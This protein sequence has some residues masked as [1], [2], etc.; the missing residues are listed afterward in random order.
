MIPRVFPHIAFVVGFYAI[1]VLWLGY[2]SL[3]E[4]VFLLRFISGSSF[5]VTIGDLIVA[6][7]ILLLWVETLLAATRTR[8]VSAWINHVL[9]GI[10]FA[11]CLLAFVSLPGFGTSTFG[12]L[13]L[14]SL[15]DFTAGIWITLVSAQNHTSIRAGT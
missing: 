5:S 7:G 12:F 8:F 13:T 4:D 11:A 6:V 14:M 2:F 9:S 15:A 10:L 3:G 1:A